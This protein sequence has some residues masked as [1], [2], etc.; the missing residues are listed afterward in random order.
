[1]LIEVPRAYPHD[2]VERHF[3]LDIKS[4]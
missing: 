4:R 3:A 1:L 2:G